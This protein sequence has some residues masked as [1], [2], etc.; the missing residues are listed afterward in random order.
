VRPGVGPGSWLVTLGDLVAV[1]EHAFQVVDYPE[2]YSAGG[3]A[4][5]GV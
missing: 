2:A 4:L 3:A 1:V 5:R